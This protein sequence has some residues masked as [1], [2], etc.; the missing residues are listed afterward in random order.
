MN[1]KTVQVINLYIIPCHIVRDSI[2]KE[3]ATHPG[4]LKKKPPESLRLASSYISTSAFFC[5]ITRDLARDGQFMMSQKYIIF[6]LLFVPHEWIHM[7]LSLFLIIRKNNLSCYD[8]I[9]KLIIINESPLRDRQYER[10]L[11]SSRRRDYASKGKMRRRSLFLYSILLLYCYCS[12][13]AF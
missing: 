7:R 2:R 11:W 5:Y 4:M 6:F 1:V 9:A 10:R 3:W 8:V 12:T 13:V